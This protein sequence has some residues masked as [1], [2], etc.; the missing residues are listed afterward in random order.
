MPVGCCDRGDRISDKAHR[1]VEC[2]TALL[3]DLFDGV[4]VLLA[5]GDSARAPNDGA[6]FVSQYGLHSRESLSLGGIDA[7]DASMRMRAA[8]DFGV[9]HT[10]QLDVAA[11]GC[12]PGDAL[13][14]VD[15]RRLMPD[16]LKGRG[17]RTG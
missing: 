15:A 7:L 3:G 17:G 1:V 2:V 4:I 5:A 13:A 16:R 8:Q 10:R 12:L 14:G 11:V 6:I 9:E